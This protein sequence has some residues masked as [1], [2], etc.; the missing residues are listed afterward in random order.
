MLAVPFSARWHESVQNSDLPKGVPVIRDAPLFLLV[1]GSYVNVPL[2]QTYT[3]S[4]GVSP[5]PI[6]DLVAPP[7]N[8]EGRLAASG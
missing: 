6:R 7:W 1:P 8:W 3:A 4:W 5:K 2:E